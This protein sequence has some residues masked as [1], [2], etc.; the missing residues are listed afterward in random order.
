M[1]GNMDKPMHQ[2]YQQSYINPLIVRA[3]FQAL[4]NIWISDIEI[5]AQL[6]IWPIPNIYY[7]NTIIFMNILIPIHYTKI[8]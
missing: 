6:T 2:T 4:K 1:K 7:I 5:S 8:Y 3:N